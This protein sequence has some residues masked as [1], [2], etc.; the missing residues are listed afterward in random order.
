M[1]LILDVERCEPFADPLV[2]KRGCR[3]QL[4]ARL[5]SRD[6][7]CDCPTVVSLPQDLTRGSVRGGKCAMKASCPAQDGRPVWTRIAKA[8]DE[9]TRAP[10][11]GDPAAVGRAD[12]CWTA[13]TVFD[14]LCEQLLAPRGFAFVVH[15]L[16]D[17]AVRA[18]RQV[19]TS[20]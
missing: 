2:H 1:S 14:K 13:E 8:F 17:N 16:E 6:A 9:R 10:P 5:A 12:R 18:P 3:T 7:V 4:D 19:L 15:F 11:V 20:G